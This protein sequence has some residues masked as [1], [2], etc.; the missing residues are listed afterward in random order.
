MKYFIVS[1][2][3]AITFFSCSK[4]KRLDKAAEKMQEFV[5]SISNYA[6]SFDPDF[7]IIPQNG[8]ELAFN[9]L[10]PNDGQNSAYMAAIDG[11]GVEELFYNG[12]FSLDEERLAMLK[13]L[14]AS[15]KIMVSEY[16]T[17]SSN[18]SDALNRNY[19]EGFICF[20]R[21][22]SN[23]HYL[24]IPDSV[25]YSNT[26]DI[27]S[28]SDAQNYLYLISTDSYSSKQAMIDAIASLI[29]MWFF[30]LFFQ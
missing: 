14:K 19:S 9:N 7:I 12:T 3:L 8:I 16:V 25:P 10:D 1:L 18:I 11:F 22:S 5:I 13:Q 20:A 23:Y 4:E 29:S 30:D 26:A 24:Q 21:T 2:I 27:N 15:K 6:R 28:L 17:E